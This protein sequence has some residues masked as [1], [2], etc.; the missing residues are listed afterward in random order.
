MHLRIVQ[1]LQ[2]NERTLENVMADF[3]EIFSYVA[4]T[5]LFVALMIP[6]VGLIVSIS[7]E[8][9][10]FEKMEKLKDAGKDVTP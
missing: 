6:L 7:R 10:E 5:C 1:I 3:Y 9:K 8:T 2:S 4:M